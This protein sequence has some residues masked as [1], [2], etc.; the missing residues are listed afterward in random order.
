MTFEA[1]QLIGFE[2]IVGIQYECLHCH[3]KQIFPI[4]ALHRAPSKC[5]NCNEEWFSGAMKDGDKR[6][7]LHL[8]A[9]VMK[10]PRHCSFEL[11]FE[12][13]CAC[14]K[15]TLLVQHAYELRKVHVA[16]YF[17]L[18]IGWAAETQGGYLWEVLNG[19][20]SYW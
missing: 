10:R 4:V 14:E 18:G 3:A 20:H 9:F 17:D 19:T 6:F 7:N 15:Q 13:I 5:M 1:R 2:D 16:P 8:S 12:E 11:I